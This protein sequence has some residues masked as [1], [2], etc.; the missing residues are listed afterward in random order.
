MAKS[1]GTYTPMMAQFLAL[2]SQHADVLLLYRMG[3]FYETFFED[4]KI[5]ARELELTLTSRD[6]GPDGQ[7]IPMAGIPHHALDNYLPRLIA[8]G[9]RVAIC[10]QM[11]DPQKAKG[12][13]RREVVR[14]VTPG[15]LLESGMLAEKH[16]NYLVAVTREG[17]GFGLAYCDASTGEFATTELPS[18]ASVRLELERLGA[19]ECLLPLDLRRIDWVPAPDRH[20]KPRSLGVLWQ[21]ALPESIQV[22]PR[23]PEDFKPESARKALMRQ[24]QVGSLEGF[25]CS[26]M[27]LATAAAGAI[28]TYLQDTQRAQLPL[29]SGLRTYHESKTM[30]I[31]GLTR[32]HLELTATARDGS[33][34]GSL[35]HL[36]DRTRTPMGARRLRQWLLAPLLDPEAIVAR[37][38]AIEELLNQPSLLRAFATAL[39]PVR[40]IERLTG[41]VAASSINGRELLALGNSLAA[42]PAIGAVAQRCQSPLLNQLAAPPELLAHL[43]TLIQDTL[44]EAPPIST[45]EGGLIREGVNEQVDAL[46]T[47]QR[48]D[49][50]WLLNFES[51]ERARTGIK[52]LKVNH[53]KAFGYYIEVTH[54]NRH[55]VPDNY[56]RKQTLVNCERFITPELKSREQDIV[57]SEER[58]F[59][60]EHSLFDDLRHQAAEQI[61]SLQETGQQLAVI[62]VLLSLAE[63]ARD[64]HYVRPSVGEDE[65]LT[66]Q[67]GRHAV[68]ENHLPVGTFVPNDALLDTSNERMMILTGP[69]M[70]GKSTYMR[71]LALIIILAQMGSFVPADQAHIGIVDRIFTRIGAVDDLSTGQSTFM[72]EMNETANLLHHATT[73]SFV[74]LDEVGRGTSTLDGLSI[75][76]AVAEH[77][78]NAVRARAIFATHYHE[79]TGLSTTQPSVRSYRV[80]VEETQ[81]DVIFLRRVVPGGADRSYGIEVARLA[82]LPPSVI[83]RARQVLGA[84][85]KNN[86]LF[87]SLKKTLVQEVPPQ[88]QLPLFEM[89][90]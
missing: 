15:T 54:A 9:Y 37:H 70:A 51:D 28:V 80:L 36:L 63:V 44:V 29:F 13:V 46:R 65:R 66:V 20:L 12:L 81:D 38:D 22:T 50:T 88:K 8:R 85:E 74:L 57:Q 33:A 6:G 16:N 14:V 39:E 78:A 79:L 87:D 17:D 90:R 3:D 47:L 25:G 2:K 27:S 73:R 49:K 58:L 61:P 53:T 82:G 32:K 71:Q 26:N 1:S 56:H 48:D 45:T 34:K 42:L 77:L 84:L 40:D 11:E 24:F 7:R 72:V 23:P 43:G 89:S 5:A 69:N 76:W 21:D 35:V 68:V 75:A 31:D 52:S 4:A 18:V 19:V 41:R 86:R 83:Q 30:V 64:R 55:L 60:L 67:G 10:E 59:R 62:D